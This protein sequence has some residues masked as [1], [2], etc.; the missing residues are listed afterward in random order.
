MSCP[1]RLVPEAS[2]HDPVLIQVAETLNKR[3]IL[4]GEILLGILW[5][6][7]LLIVLV[8]VLIWYGID[9]GSRP[10]T[11]LQREISN[12]SHRDLS[13]LAEHNVP[14][15]VRALVHAMN[16]LLAPL[17]EAMSVHLWLRSGVGEFEALLDAVEAFFYAV[18]AR[19][20][21][22]AVRVQTG[23][24]IVN[25]RHLLLNR[26]HALLEEGEFLAVLLDAG[27][28]CA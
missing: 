16:D 23:N 18:K 20:N 6:E 14:G 13:P 19:I 7:L 3:Y 21:H 4:A 12:C 24:R 15:K 28:D 11:E 5:P 10:L 2:D 25:T 27:A 8:G 9:R 22:R 17:N 1:L 26:G